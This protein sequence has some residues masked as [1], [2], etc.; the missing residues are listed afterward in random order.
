MI[1]KVHH[2]GIVVKDLE[3]A[4]R[5]YRD[6]FGVEPTMVYDSP[7]TQAKIAFIPVGEV[8]I[9]LL[10]PGDPESVTGKFLAKTGGGLHHIAYSVKDIDQRLESLEAKGIRLVDRKSRKVRD[11]ERVGFLHP[12]STHN[13]LIE[14]I[15]E[16]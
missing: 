2:V 5:L 4:V 16:D 10:E 15:Q 9:E 13:V 14:L 6:A 11:A 3:E 8:K 7:H 12:K 1:E